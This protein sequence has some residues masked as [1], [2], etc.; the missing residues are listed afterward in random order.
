MAMRRDRNDARVLICGLPAS[1]KTTFLAALWHL[2]FSDELEVALSFDSLPGEREHL[3]ALAGKWRKCEPVERTLVGQERHVSMNLR[4]GDHQV[5]VTF[6]DLSG[7]IWNAMWEFRTCPQAIASLAASCDGIL[8]FIHAD[9]IRLPIP[10]VEA[11]AQARILGEE[12]SAGPEAPWSPSSAPTQV[13]L[14][15]ILQLLSSVRAAGP[16]RLTVILSAWD[17]AEPEAK[18]P[19]AF[20]AEHLP[21]LDQYL[22]SS[23]DYAAWNVFGVSAQ[24]G[25]LD[26]DRTSLLAKDRPSQRIKVVEGETESHDLTR[27]VKWLMD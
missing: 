9:T 1:G 18:T 7:E 10:V 21:M 5:T 15:D 12:P 6:P 25:D 23:A 4:D 24:G 8:L 14:A 22:K 27:P 26:S 11:S 20:F 16:R 2:V 17:L 19:T 3:N 13:V